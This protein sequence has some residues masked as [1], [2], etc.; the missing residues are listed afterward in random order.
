MA[1]EL[2][3]ISDLVMGQITVEFQE[4]LEG[5]SDVQSNVRGVQSL[6]IPVDIT[7]IAGLC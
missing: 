1:D 3:M 2:G 6:D 7:L 5:E 4:H